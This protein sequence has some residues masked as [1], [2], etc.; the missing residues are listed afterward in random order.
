[1][2]YHKL[3]TILEHCAVYGPLVLLFTFLVYGGMHLP[4][5]RGYH[6]NTPEPFCKIS[7]VDQ[8][9]IF[10]VEIPGGNS[11]S[12]ELPDKQKK[13]PCSLFKQYNTFWIC[14]SKS[15]GCEIHNFDNSHINRIP[16]SEHLWQLPEITSLPAPVRAGPIA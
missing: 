3:K 9:N 4:D 1:M 11:P 10:E 15:A 5:P 12:Q 8:I 16:N 6:Q 7:G 13:K 2:Q 14:A